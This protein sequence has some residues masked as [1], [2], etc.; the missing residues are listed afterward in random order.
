MVADNPI[1]KPCVG[2]P[3][4]NALGLG[5]FAVFGFLAFDQL[6]FEGVLGL[7]ERRVQRVES[8]CDDEHV[9]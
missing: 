3:S 8:R 2:P 4:S 9:T 5:V 6:V 1:N 7:C